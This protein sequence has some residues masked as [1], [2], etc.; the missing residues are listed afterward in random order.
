M[1]NSE[2]KE[3]Y[4]DENTFWHITSRLNIESIKKNG[5]VPRNGKRNGKLVSAEDP[6]S[7]VFFSQGLEGVLEQAN[8]LAF[9]LDSF[10]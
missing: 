7:R 6:V 3:S 1:K 9:V 8:N 5:L 2:L 4:L 10:F